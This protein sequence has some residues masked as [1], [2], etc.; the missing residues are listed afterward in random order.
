M[1][2]GHHP[3]GWCEKRD[4]NPYGVNHTPLKRARLP[5]PPLSRVD[6]LNSYII[7]HLEWFVNTFFKKYLRFLRFLYKCYLSKIVWS[8][9]EVNSTHNGTCEPTFARIDKLYNSK[10]YHYWLC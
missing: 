2:V 7:P 1:T 9:N 4:L 5:V 6:F 3:F 8:M 10:L